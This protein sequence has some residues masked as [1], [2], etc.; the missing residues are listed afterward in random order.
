MSFTVSI[1]D[2]DVFTALRTFLLTV[3]SNALAVIQGLDNRVP[4][5]TGGFI[6]MQ[7]ITRERLA[8]NI[9]SYTLD[10]GGNNDSK[11]MTQKINYGIQIDVYSDTAADYATVISTAFRDMYAYDVF[12][13]NIK[14]L[15]CD[16]PKQLQFTNGE[17]QYEKRYM[18][19]MYLQY[20][21]TVTTP[22]QLA[23][24]LSGPTMYPVF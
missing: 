3:T 19:M 20:D 14:P 22:A 21:P 6:L 12:P 4:M 9:D 23:T 17:M 24:E 8:T 13:A 11:S 1:T 18:M 15:Y 16:D 2:S 10:L 5:P 7:G